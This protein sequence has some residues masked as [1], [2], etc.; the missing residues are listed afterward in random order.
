VG[1]RMVAGVG[2]AVC[3]WVAY[4]GVALNVD[5]DLTPFRLVQTGESDDGPM[6][7]LARERRG[8]VRPALVRQRLLEHFSET[9]ACGRT[10]LFFSHPLLARPAEPCVVP[11]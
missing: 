7:S 9:F 3:D 2:V 1:K 4:F 5:P 6:T 10:D 11:G 8:P